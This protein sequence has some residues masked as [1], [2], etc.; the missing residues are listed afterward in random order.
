M[1]VSS[2]FGRGDQGVRMGIWEVKNGG[3]SSSGKVWLGVDA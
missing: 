2:Q 3:E 1:L